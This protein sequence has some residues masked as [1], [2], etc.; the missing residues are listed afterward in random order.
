MITKT[1]IVCTIGPATEDPSVF[2]KLVDAGMDVC[3][4]NFSHGSYSDHK[5]RYKLI[6]ETSDDLAVLVDLCG[7]KIRTGEVKNG[8]IIR[9]PAS[10]NMPRITENFL[11]KISAIAPVGISKRNVASKG[12]AIMRLIP[13]KEKPRS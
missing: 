13:R 3:R 2:K 12:S 8:T 6:R 10:R 5:E 9:N 7:P 11:P 1:K 4:L